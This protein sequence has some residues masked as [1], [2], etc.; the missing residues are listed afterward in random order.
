MVARRPRVPPS[1]HA[2]LY[3]RAQVRALTQYGPYIR[4]YLEV[5]RWRRGCKATATPPPSMLLLFAKRCIILSAMPGISKRNTSGFAIVLRICSP[6]HNL[7]LHGLLLLLLLT[8][9]RSIHA[10]TSPLSASR[11][12]ESILF[13]D[14]IASL[15]YET[16]I[17]IDPR[18]HAR[19]NNAKIE[20][21]SKALCETRCSSRFNL[22]QDYYHDR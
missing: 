12:G 22:R 1:L 2:P 6:I 13:V 18:L 14:P 17:A 9:L 15:T 4:A 21:W 20:S 8:S 7:P 5:E 3:T 11:D 16:R 10:A 19:A